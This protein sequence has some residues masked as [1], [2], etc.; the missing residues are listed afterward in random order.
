MTAMGRHP[1]ITTLGFA[2]LLVATTLGGPAFADPHRERDAY[3][4]KANPLL[5]PDDEFAKYEIVPAVAEPSPLGA[6]PH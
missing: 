2:I 4:G 3:F 1:A 6:A 5:S